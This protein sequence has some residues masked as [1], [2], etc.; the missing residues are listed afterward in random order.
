LRTDLDAD[1]SALAE[2]LKNLVEF[3]QDLT[4]NERSAKNSV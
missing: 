1:A 2:C 4:G 3:G